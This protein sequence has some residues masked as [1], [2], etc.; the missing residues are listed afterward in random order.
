[1][2]DRN[3]LFLA[4]NANATMHNL[5]PLRGALVR[6]SKAWADYLTEA[7]RRYADRTDI[8]FT[9]HG[10][11]R[12]GRETITAYMK[13]HRDAYKYLHDQTVRLM[14]AGLT[15]TEIAERLELPEVLARQFYNR[16]YYGTMSHN[17]KAVYQRYMGWYDGNPASLNPLPPEEAS[18]RYVEAMG[19][20]PAVM[21]RARAA[22][23]AA[24]YR[25][26]AQLLN[27]VVFADPDNADA[28]AAL[29][30]TYTQ[31]AYQAESG[32]WRNVYLTGAQE[33]T[34]GV[35][36]G[37]TNTVALDMIRATPTTM[38]LDFIA[39][40]LN[41]DRAVGKTATINLVLTDFGE[42][43]LLSLANSALVHEA[44]V[45][46]PKAD[47]TLTLK[48]ADFLALTFGFVKLEDRLAS[49]DV[50]V[51][52]D[53]AAVATLIGLLDPLDPAFPVVT[54]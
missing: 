29:A 6:D 20:A 4:E 9:A 16:G 34:K 10:W 26:A 2:P 8:I 11:P 25:W 19:G 41:G 42:T 30:A 35:F 31:M 47:A 43:H 40:R 13:T 3:M 49:G 38:L 46:E 7:I 33:L 54:P 37:G 51:D 53:P 52:G 27:H 18:K 45:T 32:V 17:A 12:W 22:H 5:L 14:N 1:M 28:R 24:D 21:A 39:V 50:T 23:E 44:G 48:R 36:K 15:G